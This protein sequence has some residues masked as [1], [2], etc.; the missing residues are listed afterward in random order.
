MAHDNS[1][2]N[3]AL[4]ARLGTTPKTC[5][6][7]LFFAA[8]GQATH[9][10][11]ALDLV[12]LNMQFQEDWPKYKKITALLIS[13]H[14][15]LEKFRSTELH[16][17]PLERSTIFLY[18]STSSRTPLESSPSAELKYAILSSAGRD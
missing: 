10:W 12:S 17:A 13:L 3:A 4:A 1:G 9:C 11:K 14:E 7:S 6:L 8:I 15:N 18:R 16:G 2:T 5:E